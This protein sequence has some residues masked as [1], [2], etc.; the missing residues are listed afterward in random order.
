M[1]DSIHVFDDAMREMEKMGLEP[2]PQIAAILTL[3]DA[4]QGVG[5]MLDRLGMN[6][7][8]L[9]KGSGGT[10]DRIAS[11]LEGIADTYRKR[12]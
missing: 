9:E 11:A 1:F 10:T 2:D 6:K 12:R 8:R 4:V 7:G 5:W 3:A